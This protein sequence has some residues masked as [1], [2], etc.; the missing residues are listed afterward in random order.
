MQSRR[1][2]AQPFKQ[3]TERK[4]DRESSIS[5][6][7]EKL[8]SSKKLIGVQQQVTTRAFNHRM[9]SQT[10]RS[11]LADDDEVVKVSMGEAFP[12]ELDMNPFFAD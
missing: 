8:F 7:R 11:H 5:K 1:P 10:E 12:A 4:D 6:L 3:E 2:K 9:P